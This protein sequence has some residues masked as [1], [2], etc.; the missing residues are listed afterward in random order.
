M[1]HVRASFPVLWIVPPAVFSRAPARG[2]R[3]SCLLGCVRA[4]HNM[5]TLQVTNIPHFISQD[6][7]SR[8]FLQLAGC[9]GCRVL[10]TESGT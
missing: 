4:P 9:L 6:E 7:F 2:L 5:S 1:L 8:L 10:K 3:T